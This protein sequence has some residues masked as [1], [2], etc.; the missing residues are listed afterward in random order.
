VGR[1][2]N[3]PFIPNRIKEWG[4]K[5]DGFEQ[6]RAYELHQLCEAMRELVANEILNVV[7]RKDGNTLYKLAS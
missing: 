2:K 6:L 5:Q 1:N 7:V 3:N 4:S